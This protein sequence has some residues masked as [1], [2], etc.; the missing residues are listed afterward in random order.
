MLGE[1]QKSHQLQESLDRLE[2]KIDLDK[3]P[4][5]KGAIYNSY[6]DN[7]TTCHPATRVDLLHNI[8]DW[9]RD[10]DSKSIFWLSGWAGIGNQQFLELAEWLA[11]QGG[12]DGVD[13]GA[14]F[15]I[16]LQKVRSIKGCTS[17]SHLKI[18][19]Y[20]CFALNIA[21]LILLFSPIY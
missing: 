12:R 11:G 17:F 19:R 1:L 8:Y 21:T 14:S 6:G 16:N 10:P 4:Y 13:L 18:L 15:F 5:A 7:H 20:K 9:V 3:L 2:T